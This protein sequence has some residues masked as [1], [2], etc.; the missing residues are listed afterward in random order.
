MMNSL[1]RY[2]MNKVTSSASMNT[3]VIIGSKYKLKNEE[4]TKLESLDIH[5]FTHS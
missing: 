2:N 1:L 3:S 4:G 5:T